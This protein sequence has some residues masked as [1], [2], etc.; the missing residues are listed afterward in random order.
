MGQQKQVFSL[1]VFLYSFHLP[2]IWYLFYFLSQSF[3]PTLFFILL[4]L[5]LQDYNTYE[6]KGQ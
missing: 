2:N 6:A 4:L 3:D 5:E 1:I